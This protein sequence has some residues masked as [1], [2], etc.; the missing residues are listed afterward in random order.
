MA[1]SHTKKGPGRTH[2]QCQLTREP[3]TGQHLGVTQPKRKYAETNF[4]GN[5]QGKEY[6][7]QREH[8]LLTRLTRL[9]PN[10]DTRATGID[11]PISKAQAMG[12]IKAR[13]SK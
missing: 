4:G 11:V 10:A 6:L 5:W 9:G 8:D 12:I 3:T 13:R 1:R 2:G 7:S